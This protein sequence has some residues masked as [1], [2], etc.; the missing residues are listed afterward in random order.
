MRVVPAEPGAQG[1]AGPLGW[2]R[3]WVCTCAFWV[4]WLHLAGCGGDRGLRKG[5][6]AGWGGQLGLWAGRP[7]KGGCQL[8][9]AGAWRDE[10]SGLLGGQ[11]PRTPGTTP[12][13][14][15]LVELVPRS[16]QTPRPGRLAGHAWAAAWLLRS[17]LW[18]APQELRGER[19][20]GCIPALWAARALLRPF[21]SPLSLL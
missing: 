5:Q 14:G 12:L 8:E 15:P 10:G 3:S 1:W 4:A 17:R 6:Q 13:T 19:A 9:A 7:R 18:L 2:V 16:A 20:V 11:A 21:P